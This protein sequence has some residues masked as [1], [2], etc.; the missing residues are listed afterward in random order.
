MHNIFKER[1]YEQ[2]SRYSKEESNHTKYPFVYSYCG[3]C[4]I[5]YFFLNERFIESGI[6]LLISGLSDM[7]DG[8]IARKFNQVTQLGKILDPIADKLTLIAVVICLAIL[9]P[10]VWPIVIILMSKDILMLIGGAVLLC[11]KIRPP[12]AKWYGK[13]ATAIFYVSITTMVCL[14]AIFE[15]K[16]DV[17]DII[18]MSL[19]LIAMIVAFVSYAII[20]VKLIK[21]RNNNDIDKIE[22]ESKAK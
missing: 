19:T 14:S 5:G 1:I 16:N 17:L 18:L 4:S 6:Y 15:Y 20:F 11:M 3:N 10:S 22:S 12:A 7:F 8:A 9:F 21:N 2:G 13:V